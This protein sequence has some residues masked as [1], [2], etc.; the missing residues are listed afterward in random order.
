MALE[1]ALYEV[2]DA[3]GTVIA[4]EWLARAETVHRQLR[5][6][7]PGDYAERLCRVFGGGGR[8]VVAAEG[9]AVRG[10]AL[11]RLVENT[12]EGRRLYV[13]DLVTD[14]DYRS[15]GVGHG[16]LAY[17]EGRARAL[18][19]DVLSLDSGT[20][21]HDA[22]RFYFREGFVIPSFCFRKNLK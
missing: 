19:C 2:T 22:H 12:Y 10:L 3:A 20:Q 14:A 4:P 18:D 8:M 9:D 15:R 16:L 11:W 6:K 1:W 13:D 17:L 7:L 5:D 21:R